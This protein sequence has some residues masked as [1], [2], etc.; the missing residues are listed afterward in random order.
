MLG[1]MIW[2][3]GSGNMRCGGSR[4]WMAIS[5]TRLGMRLPERR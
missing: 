1:S 3:S 5:V 4:N 2:P